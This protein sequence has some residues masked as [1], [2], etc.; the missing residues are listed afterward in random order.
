VALIVPIIVYGVLIA[1]V[2]ALAAGPQIS[3]DSG[4]AAV[5]LVVVYVLVFLASAYVQMAYLSG[6]LDIADGKPVTVGSF[7]TPRNF[8]PGVGAALLVGLLTAIG[9][10]LLIIPGLIFGFL[11]QFTIA[12]VIDRS[13]W[14]ID[15]LKASIATATNNVGGA[16][17]SYLVQIAVL[18]VGQLLCGL[19]LFVAF[20]V[21]VLIQTY[22]YRLLSG[23]AVV[24]AQ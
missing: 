16:L 15:A 6:C 14:P 3:L 21:A 2:V 12:F 7:F 20:P 22:T 18:L 11:A 13:L 17:L 19:G 24:P 8:G 4:V 23:G 1:V 9:W 10:L 5:V